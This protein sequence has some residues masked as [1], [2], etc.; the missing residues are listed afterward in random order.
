[1]NEFSMVYKR[2]TTKSITQVSVIYYYENHPKHI[3]V[4][5]VKYD[6]TDILWKKS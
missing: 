4:L 6:G 1:M 2:G 5:D 3:P